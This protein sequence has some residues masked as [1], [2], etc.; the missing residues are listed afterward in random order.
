M[1]DGN[2]PVSRE[3][4]ETLN[5][6]SRYRIGMVPANLATGD[7]ATL[8]D[9]LARE[10]VEFLIVEGR[11]EPLPSDFPVRAM[12][13][14]EGEDAVAATRRLM[15]ECPDY[16]PERRWA[17]ALREDF[18]VKQPQPQQQPQQHSQPQQQ[19]AYNP[20]GAY[21]QQAQPHERPPMPKNYLLWSVLATI[22]C[23]FIPGIVAL[24]FSM[25]VTSRY[26]RNDFEGAERASRYAQIWIIVSV[27]MSVIVSTLYI[28]LMLVTAMAAL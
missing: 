5:R 26:Y 18:S 23:S 20:Y 7:P 19:P 11:A 22:I 21:Q 28:P 6:G 16:G 1:T 9:A 13:I 10:G 2:A 25:Q 14:T 4:I 12:Y 8:A 15:E 27:V 24:V 3:M 17:E